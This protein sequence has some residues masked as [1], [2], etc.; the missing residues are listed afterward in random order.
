MKS[1]PMCESDQLWMSKKCIEPGWLLPH[2][3]F[4]KEEPSISR[5]LFAWIHNAHFECRSPIFYGFLKLTSKSCIKLKNA[6]EFQMPC[7]FFPSIFIIFL[8]TRLIFLLHQ[9]SITDASKRMSLF[10]FS[11]GFYF[12]VLFSKARLLHYGW[13]WKDQ[14]SLNLSLFKG[15]RFGLLFLYVVL[16]VPKCVPNCIL[17]SKP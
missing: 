1:L 16:D 5:S 13:F 11:L 14:N 7:Y 3:L 9:I 17:G 6:F 4:S 8:K 15:G 10:L 12:V 2:L